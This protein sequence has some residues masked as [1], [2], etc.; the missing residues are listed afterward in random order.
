MNRLVILGSGTSFGVPVIGCS[1]AVCTSDDP[2][3]RRTRVAAVVEIGGARLLID[4]PPELRLQL[5]R[6]GIDGVDAV[7][8]THEHADHVHGIDDLRAISIHGGSLPLYGTA[9]T[10]EAIAAR[11]GYIFDPAVQ[12]PR[13]SSKPQLVA[14]PVVPGVPTPMAGID[15]LPLAFNHGAL[16]V[17]GF[18]FGSVAYLTDVKMADDEAIEQ[19]RGVEQLVLNALFEKPHPTHLSIA[20]ACELATRIGASQ[21]Y[22]THLTHRY[23][24]RDLLERLPAGVTPAFDGLVIEF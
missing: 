12:P 17:L 10:L 1:C 4:T 20:E 5:V 7:L 15:V 8:Y 21:T 23:P 13:G 24:H 2:R 22:L 18:R 14:V 6:E 16:D 9:E 11:F 3:D 19:L